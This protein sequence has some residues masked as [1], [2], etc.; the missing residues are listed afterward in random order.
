[1]EIVSILNGAEDWAIK[2]FLA[3]FFASG[4]FSFISR[5]LNRAARSLA[6]F[7]YDHGNDCGLKFSELADGIRFYVLAYFLP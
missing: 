6:K 5:E 2:F 3:S 7:C 1:M 4:D